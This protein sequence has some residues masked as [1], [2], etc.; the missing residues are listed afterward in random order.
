MPILVK[1]NLIRGN[2]GATLFE[3]SDRINVPE[4]IL[5]SLEKGETKWLRFGMLEMICEE[6]KCQPGDILEYVPKK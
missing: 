2:N 3:L 6:L 4:A 5:S 1:L